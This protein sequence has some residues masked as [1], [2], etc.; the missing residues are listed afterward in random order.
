VGTLTG[1]L[2][3]LVALPHPAA[4]TPLSQQAASAQAKVAKVKAELESLRTTLEATIQQ[5][6]LANLKLTAAQ[7]S[8]E[9]ATYQLQ[10]AR[11]RLIVAQ[12]R[13]T[14]RIVAIYEQPPLDVLDVI[15]SAHSFTDISTT[16][17]GLNEISASDSAM[18]SELAR[19]AALVQ[20]KR[21]ALVV[22][23][24]RARA[25]FVQASAKKASIQSAVARQQHI[26]A[27]AKATVQRIQK[28]E[29]AAAARAEAAAR[30]AAKARDLAGA[31]NPAGAGSYQPSSAGQN[32]RPIPPPPYPPGHPEVIAIARKYLGIPYVY[33]AADPSVG[34]DCSGLVMYCYAQIGIS[35]PHYSGYQQNMGTPVPMNALIPGDLVFMGYPVSYHVALYAGNGQVIQAPYTGAV[36]SYGSLAGFQYAVRL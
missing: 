1:C 16:L 9:Q 6:D 8:V 7:K 24:S 36:V 23:R 4:A 12:E 32:P 29:A 15:F 20:A 33:G 10:I 5:Y 2:L 18:V 26:F 13:F 11:S 25:Y 28:E 19:A 30:A 31:T 17:Q 14:K 34:F 3:V 21:D 22:A 35:L 27:T